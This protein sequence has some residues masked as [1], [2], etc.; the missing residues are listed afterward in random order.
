MKHCDATVMGVVS[1][2]IHPLEC[3]VLRT[4]RGVR[5]STRSINRFIFQ[6]QSVMICD[7][8]AANGHVYFGLVNV[9]EH[10]I[11]PIYQQMNIGRRSSSAGKS[12]ASSHEGWF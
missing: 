6:E 7:S 3:V 9:L 2:P 8:L 4:A 11:N 12:E 1:I 5:L 10:V